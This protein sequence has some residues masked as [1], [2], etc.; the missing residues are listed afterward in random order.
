MCVGLRADEPTRGGIF[1]DEVES[2]YPLREWG[3]GIEDVREY[4]RFRDVKIPHRTDCARCPFQRLSEWRDL[5]RDHPDIYRKAEEQEEEYGHTYR[6]PQRDTWPADLK[7]LRNEFERGVA[8][9]GD[10]KRLQLPLFEGE[11]DT[12]K[13]CRVCTL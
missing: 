9:R 12:A 1:S 11:E 2:R 5:W 4:L 7:S 10:W 3:W 6:N 8:L 13:K